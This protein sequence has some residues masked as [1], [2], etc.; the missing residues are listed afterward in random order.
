[1]AAATGMCQP[2]LA[3]DAEKT[4]AYLNQKRRADLRRRSIRER[5]NHGNDGHTDDL[6]RR[7][8]EQANFPPPGLS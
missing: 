5:R 1:M 7:Y 8:P 2:D 3:H 6:N 4:I